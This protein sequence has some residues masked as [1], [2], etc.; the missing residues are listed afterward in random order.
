[1]TKLSSREQGKKAEQLACNY[2]KARGLKLVT[3]NFQGQQGEID[4]IMQDKDDL[5]FVEV[6][7]RNNQAYGSGA[8]TVSHQ[9][10]RRLKNT[11]ELYLQIHYGNRVPPCRFDVISMSLRPE[12]KQFEWI[13]NAF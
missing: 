12:E 6:R 10:Q 3:K 1:M 7:L 5:V 13:R 4:L 11:A 2:L 9:K 8:D